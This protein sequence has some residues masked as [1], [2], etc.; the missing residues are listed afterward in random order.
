VDQE[1]ATCVQ[2]ACRNTRMA[3]PRTRQDIVFA[4]S[5][6]ARFGYNPG[7]AHWEAAKRVLRY[8]KGTT[9]RRPKL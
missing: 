2:G 6:L 9:K 7:R 8:L 3:F 1:M 5:S 4:A